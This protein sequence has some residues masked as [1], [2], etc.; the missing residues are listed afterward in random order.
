MKYHLIVFEKDD[1]EWLQREHG[2][3]NYR[4]D[5]L[6]EADLLGVEVIE[7]GGYTVDYKSYAIIEVT[8]K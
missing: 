8:R 1:N 7:K 2:V 5:A 6:S 3:Y 4:K